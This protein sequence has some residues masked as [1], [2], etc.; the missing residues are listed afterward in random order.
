MTCLHCN[1]KLGFFSRYKDTPFCSEEHLRA[2][3]E[4]LERA[5][6]ERLGSKNKPT[7]KPLQDLSPAQATPASSRLDFASQPRREVQTSSPGLRVAAP[8]PTIAPTSKPPASFS[9]TADPVPAQQ[10]QAPFSEDFLLEV[11]QAAVALHPE[12]PHTPA[13]AFSILLSAACYTPRASFPNFDFNLA[14]QAEPVAIESLFAPLPAELPIVPKLYSNEKFSDINL[15]LHLSSY[16]RL[17]TY[18]IE[19][20]QEEAIPL[21]YEPALS[22]LPHPALGERS[23]IPPRPRLRYP[24]A[25]STASTAGSGTNVLHLGSVSLDRIISPVGPPVGSAAPTKL[26]SHLGPLSDRDTTAV[27]AGEQASLPIDTAN[28]VSFPAQ[29][30]LDFLSSSR[31]AVPLRKSYSGSPLGAA[32][33]PASGLNP[34]RDPRR[35]PALCFPSAY[36]LGPKLP[37]RPE[38]TVS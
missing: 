5:L 16:T 27:G 8:L 21:E 7:L 20:D 17:P 28:S 11:P 25:A 1:K 38:S 36:Q 18:S 34:A 12:R 3:Q 37:P 31:A 32:L 22:S 19:F 6:M 2:H 10:P 30:N 33:Q 35:L 29:V 24:Y 4:E 14:R 23:E 15:K 13:S 26:V 9:P